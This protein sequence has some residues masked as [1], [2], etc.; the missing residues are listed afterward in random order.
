MTNDINTALSNKFDEYTTTYA[1]KD[2]K[3]YLQLEKLET[4][5]KIRVNNDEIRN[6]ET[7]SNELFSI[8]GIIISLYL[9]NLITDYFPIDVSAFTKLPQIATILYSA[10]YVVIVLV[11]MFVV[12]A[13]EL[14]VYYFFIKKKKQKKIQIISENNDY[15]YV[16]LMVIE[17]RINE[18]A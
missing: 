12:F 8:I 18:L 5:K 7:D 15:L 16:L 3:K 1:S 13:A 11:M 14:C 4:D 17:N 10:I 9:S 2:L 6:L